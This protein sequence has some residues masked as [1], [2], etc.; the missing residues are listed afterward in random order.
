[1]LL[2][3]QFRSELLLCL[4]SKNVYAG[5]DD[6]GS[7]DPRYGQYCYRPVFIHQS[8]CENNIFIDLQ[9]GNMSFLNSTITSR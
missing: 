5:Y 2:H 4:E 6:I 9:V 8:Q 3:S 7:Q 1:M